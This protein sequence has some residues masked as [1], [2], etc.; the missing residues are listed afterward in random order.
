MASLKHWIAIVKKNTLLIA[1][2]LM[3]KNVLAYLRMIL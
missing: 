3:G 1:E 2:W